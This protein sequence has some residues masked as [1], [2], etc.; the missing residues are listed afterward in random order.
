MALHQ[1]FPA[2]WEIVNSRM[3][4]AFNDN[5]EGSPMDF[6]DVRDDRIYTY[7]G[8]GQGRKH[9]Y[10]FYLTAAYQGEYY[11]PNVSCAAMY[12]NGNV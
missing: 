1:V 12:D 8:I 7:F 10:K 3:S 9:T 2:G 11:M 4:N 5:R 6:Q